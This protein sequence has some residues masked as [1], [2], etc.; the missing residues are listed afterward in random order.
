M[1]SRREFLQMAG[2]TAAMIGGQSAW[3]TLAAQR[4]YR[5]MIC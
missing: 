3:S 1:F 2:V 5:K 4:N